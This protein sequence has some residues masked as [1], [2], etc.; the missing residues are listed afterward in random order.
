MSRTDRIVICVMLLIIGTCSFILTILSIVMIVN[1]LNQ[2]PYPI[3][4][5]VEALSVERPIKNIDTKNTVSLAESID[6][7]DDSIEFFE[8]LVRCVEAE[9]G[10]ET[11]L[12]KRLVC[13]VV[14]NRYE[15]W[16][17][18]TIVDVIN[19]PHQFSVVGD[20]RIHTVEPSES[21]YRIVEEELENRTNT[22]VLYFRAD[23][24]HDFGT[25]MF[26]E[27]GHYFSKD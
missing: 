15:N 23:H 17:Y 12:G 24:Y 8:Y 14:L 9:A 3:D 7:V 5:V 13:D 2:V 18:D 16:G 4:P 19:D 11:E 25:P 1:G 26:Q 22:E 10:G 27:K 20:G 6:S 21:T